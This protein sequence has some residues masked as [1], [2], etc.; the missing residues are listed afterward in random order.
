MQFSN[1]ASTLYL[2]LFVKEYNLML[3]ELASVQ[4]WI[5]NIEQILIY[6]IKWKMPYIISFFKNFRTDNLKSISICGANSFE[7][8][9]MSY[10][11][12]I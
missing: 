11:K 5:P 8:I 6:D 10:R 4:V 9:H 2:Y 12:Y 1:K 3:K 7:G